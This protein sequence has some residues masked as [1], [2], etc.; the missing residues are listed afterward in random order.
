MSFRDF[1]SFNLAMLGKQG[2]KLLSEPNAKICCI[3]KAKYYPRGDFLN[4]NIGHNPS[5]AWRSILAS[6]VV[7]KKGYRW[8]IGYGGHINIWKDPWLRDSSNFFVEKAMIP[9]LHDWRVQDLMVMGSQEW[10]HE[11]IESIFE[12]RDTNEIT[13]I[14]LV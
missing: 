11:I 6:Q 14:P 4:A 2:W 9:E 3:Y 10:D 7:L 1:Y 5:F 12:F 8:R 13:E